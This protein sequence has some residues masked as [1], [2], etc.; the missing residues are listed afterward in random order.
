MIKTTTV[1]RLPLML[2]AVASVFAWFQFR[3][4]VKAQDDNLTPGMLF[5]PLT[6]A[7]GEHIELC[8]ANLG[9]GDITAIVHFRNMTSGEVTAN[10]TLLIKSGGGACSSFYYGPGTVV[11]MARGSGRAAD[12]VSPSNALISTMAV[13]NNKTTGAI[14]QGV[15]KLWLKGL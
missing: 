9:D 14:V 11:G 15:P 2:L 4:V 13:V 12:W 6:V 8:A 5:G 3:P 10:E 1:V 7:T